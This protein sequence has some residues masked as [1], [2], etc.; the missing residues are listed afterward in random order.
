MDSIKHRKTNIILDLD[1]TCINS[2]SL[3][4]E[5]NKAP[6][7]YQKKFKY[8]DMPKYYRIFQR[9]HLQEFLDYIFDKYNVSV[10]TSADKDY[11]LFIIDNI[12]IGKKKNRKL[13]YTF[14]GSHSFLSEN[15]YKSPKDLRMLWE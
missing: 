8:I 12:I 11:A 15:F 6:V 10:F 14:V 4:S 7:E 2:L 5:V 13:K 3:N 1:S 9:P